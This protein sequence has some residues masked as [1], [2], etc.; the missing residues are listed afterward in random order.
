MANGMVFGHLLEEL[1]DG[2]TIFRDGEGK[3]MPLGST[4]ID[5][6]IQAGLAIVVTT[7]I[8]SNV[9]D[10]PIEA[11]L[12]MPVGFNAV[13]TGLSAK[14]D[15]RSLRAVAKGKTAARTSYEGAIDQGKMAILHEEV[16]RG[17]HVLSVGQLA[18]GKEVSVEL[19]TV[20]PLAAT[21][22]GLLLRLPMT[23]GHLYGVSPLQPADDLITSASVR[24]TASVRVRSDSG[25]PHLVGFG[26]LSDGEAVDVLMNRSIEIEI[27]GSRTG[28]LLG[29]SA[30]GRQVQLDLRREPN[31]ENSLKLAILI[32][33]SGSTGS[34]VGTDGQTVLSAIRDGLAQSLKIVTDEDLIAVWQFDDSCQRLGTGRGAEVLQILE[35]LKRPGGGTRLGEAIKAVARTGAQDILVLTDGQTW[36]RLSPQV[37]GKNVRVSAVLVGRASL[38]VNIGHFCAATGGDLFY[39]PDADVEKSVSVALS[40]MRSSRMDRHLEMDGSDP[41]RF[42]QTLGGVTVSA[43]WSDAMAMGAADDIGRYAAALCLGQ[44]N[45]AAA[46]RLAVMEGLC[47]NVTSLVLIDEAGALS[48]GIS[49]TRKIPLMNADDDG[50][51]GDFIE[52][53]NAILPMAR[54]SASY[55]AS[56][57]RAP[58]MRFGISSLLP[59]PN[60]STPSVPSGGTPS[61]E[62]LS[63]LQA[64][65]SKTPVPSEQRRKLRS[66]LDDGIIEPAKQEALR[67]A[68][69]HRLAEVAVGIDWE[70]QANR[71]LSLAFDGLLVSEQTALERLVQHVLALASSRSEDALKLDLLAYLS[72]RFV[73]HSRAARRFAVKVLNGRSEAAFIAEYDALIFSDVIEGK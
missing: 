16:L 26:S 4:A 51:L 35:K 73:T 14:I 72:L 50:Q 71:F 59:A 42:V 70:N 3:P 58:R 40:Q 67:K 9:E 13:V 49:E 2:V 53:R 29:V 60:A 24:H 28:T 41:V 37:E 7:R 38:D 66:F 46:E 22:N 64:A 63:R 55:S 20:M 47:S 17:I 61:P 68:K 52:D 31:G 69:E 56:E 5:V 48:D 33:R 12:T 10:V 62:A 15:G 27:E 54:A 39:T 25:V 36:D 11:V 8:F 65:V 30:S 57:D 23:T 1:N 45:D 44:L 21:E 43:Q 34:P 32:D 18:P 6:S 19:R